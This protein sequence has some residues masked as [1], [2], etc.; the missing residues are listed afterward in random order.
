MNNRLPR[1]IATADAYAGP[2][3]AA[4]IRAVAGA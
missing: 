1:D 2:A 3:S 4:G